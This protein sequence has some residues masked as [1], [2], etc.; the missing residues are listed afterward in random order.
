MPTQSFSTLSF[1]FYLTHS[2]LVNSAHPRF[3]KKSMST[4]VSVRFRNEQFFL[5]ARPH[6]GFDRRRG[7]ATLRI[8]TCGERRPGGKGPFMDGH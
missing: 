8:K 5:R 4:C 6:K 3:F 2:D 7:M 1:P